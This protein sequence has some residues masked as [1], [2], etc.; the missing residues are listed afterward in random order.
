VAKKTSPPNTL[1]FKPGRRRKSL[2]EWNDSSRQA[3]VLDWHHRA[4]EFGLDVEHRDD[5]DRDQPYDVDPKRL[6]EDE[7]PEAFAPQHVDDDHE[8][9]RED[10]EEERLE[11]GMTGRE[12]VDLVR[13]YLQHIGRR[14]LLKAH[15]EVALGERIEKAQHELVGTFA[16][17]PSAV[18]TL[19]ALADRIRSKGDPAAELILLPEGG[20]LGNAQIVPVLRAFNRIKKRRCVIETLRAKL[21]QPRL[22][23]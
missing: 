4:E 8:F 18:Q 11:P 9:E 13:V 22:G 15:E 7:E 12:D 16:E 6:L 1:A 20:E 3:Q 10:E 5:A 17:I 2:I 23:V 19:I 14:K 21:D